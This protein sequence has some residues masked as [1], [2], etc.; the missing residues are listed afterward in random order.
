MAVPNTSALRA[1]SDADFLNGKRSL[2]PGDTLSHM[3]QLVMPENANPGGITF[4]GQVRPQRQDRGAVFFC[5]NAANGADIR[6][7]QATQVLAWVEQAAYLSAAR[8]SATS[9]Q[10]LTAAMDAVSFKEPT[11]VGDVLFFTSQVGSLQKAATALPLKALC[12]SAP[13]RF[14]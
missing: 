14:S 5:G 9:G 13:R 2:S 12:S 3:I 11:T 6:D 4:G 10:M 7:A 1:V 8:L